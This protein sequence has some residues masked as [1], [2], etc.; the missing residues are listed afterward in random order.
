M[1]L[2]CGCKSQLTSLESGG[3]LWSSS[4]MYTSRN[5][6][7]NDCD[8]NQNQDYAEL[9][10]RF[11][12]LSL[13]DSFIDFLHCYQI[14]KSPLILKSSRVHF[15]IPQASSLLNNLVKNFTA[16]SPRRLT[17]LHRY[18]RISLGLIGFPPILLFNVILTSSLL[19]LL[20]PGPQPTP[21][22]GF[23][24]FSL[25]SNSSKQPLHLPSSLIVH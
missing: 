1:L 9:C 15:S 4:V 11:L 2:G 10:D 22:L 23:L 16:T 6:C 14:C 20:F 8:F 5:M 3:V 7:A 21:P 24:L 18:Y 25:E 19:D 13:G 12:G 17:F